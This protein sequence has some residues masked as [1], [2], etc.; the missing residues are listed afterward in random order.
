MVLK[1]IKGLAIL[2]LG[3]GIR[4][5]PPQAV[6]GLREE[7]IKWEVPAALQVVR[8]QSSASLGTALSQGS[9]LAQVPSPGS[10]HPVRPADKGNEDL[11]P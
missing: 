2:V 3:A 4:S 9:C 5:T 6:Q 8:G 7:G 1:S 11:A 10:N